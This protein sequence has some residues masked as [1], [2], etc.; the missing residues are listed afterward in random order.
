MKKEEIDIKND[1]QA[2]DRMKMCLQCDHF[3]EPT[4]QCKKCNCFMP[5]KVRLVDASCPVG[6]W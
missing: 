6:K 4:R 3:F 2:I 5:I 1:R